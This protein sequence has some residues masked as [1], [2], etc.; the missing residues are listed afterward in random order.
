MCRL[1]HVGDWGTQFGMLIANLQD[2]FP[3][4]TTVSPA[5]S[6]LQAFYKVIC[7]INNI[8]GMWLRLKCQLSPG[9]SGY[10]V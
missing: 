6:D 5:V 10:I 9:T 3:E 7:E 4:Y 2:K 8:A 1:N